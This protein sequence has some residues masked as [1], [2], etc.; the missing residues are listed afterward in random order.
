MEATVPSWGYSLSVYALSRVRMSA[1]YELPSRSW[2]SPKAAFEVSET[3]GARR[4]C[5]WRPPAV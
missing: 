3:H 5:L 4:S 2:T 1:P